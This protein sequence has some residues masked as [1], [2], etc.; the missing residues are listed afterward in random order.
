[1][2]LMEHMTGDFCLDFT[3]F[4]YLLPDT[5]PDAHRHKAFCFIVIGVFSFVRL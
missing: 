1:M 4:L 5:K 2:E 3:Y